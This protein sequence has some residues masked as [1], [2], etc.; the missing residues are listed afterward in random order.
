MVFNATFNNISV[1]ATVSFIGGG[2]VG[3]FLFRPWL[4]TKKVINGNGNIIQVRGTTK[5]L[6][7]KE[8]FA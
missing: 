6:L 2:G 4:F 3:Y 1:I 5:P 7:K 8:S